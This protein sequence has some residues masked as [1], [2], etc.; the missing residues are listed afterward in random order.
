[1]MKYNL[2][3]TRLQHRQ[4]HFDLV[5]GND[6]SNFLVKVTVLLRLLPPSSHHSGFIILLSLK[7]QGN[8]T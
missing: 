1:M 6:L 2:E 5:T 8:L 7:L 3:R 4:P